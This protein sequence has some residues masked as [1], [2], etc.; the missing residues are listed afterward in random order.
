[1]EY[2]KEQKIAQLEGKMEVSKMYSAWWIAFST[3]PENLGR[4]VHHGFSDDPLFTKEELIND[5]LNTSKNH[6]KRYS[7]F[8]ESK[9]EIMGQ[10]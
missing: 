7:E 8:L 5:A 3:S 9:I 1:M 2:T 4:T 10:N 6:I